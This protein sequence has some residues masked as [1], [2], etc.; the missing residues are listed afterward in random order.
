MGSYIPRFTVYI[1]MYTKVNNPGL[2]RRRC[3]AARTGVGSGWVCVGVRPVR[4]VRRG[5]LK[6][7]EASEC[8]ARLQSAA[9]GRGQLDPIP[10]C[11]R[12]GQSAWQ[13]SAQPRRS[14]R[15]SSTRASRGRRRCDG[16]GSVQPR[17]VARPGQRQSPRSRLAPHPADLPAFRSGAGLIDCPP[18][19]E[20]ASPATP[21]TRSDSGGRLRRTARP[22]ED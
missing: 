10:A 20:L 3:S 2:C 5:E 7:G 13:S 17:S 16:D 21:A 4:A 19:C 18:H 12:P 9:R 11:L 8:A 1:Y 6:S 14:S 22:A 15:S